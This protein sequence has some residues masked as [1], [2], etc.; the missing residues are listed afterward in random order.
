[1]MNNDVLDT[2]EWSS[3]NAY[4]GM[5]RGPLWLT[6]T[7]VLERF[8]NPSSYGEFVRSR[9]TGHH[10]NQFYEA[11]FAQKLVLGDSGFVER[12]RKRIDRPDARIQ[13]GIT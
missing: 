5:S 10:A 4:E 1:M 6:K 8:A 13:P 7:E 12:V 2:F 9:P 3:F 11:P